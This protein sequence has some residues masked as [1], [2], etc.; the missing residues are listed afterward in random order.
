M[1]FP[2]PSSHKPSTEE[3]AGGLPGADWEGRA[4]FQGIAP[5]P[6]LN[7]DSSRSPCTGWPCHRGMAVSQR[8]GR[9]TEDS[10]QDGVIRVP[11]S[12]ARQERECK[13]ASCAQARAFLGPVSPAPWGHR[14]QG[15]QVSP[16]AKT[17]TGPLGKPP[18]LV[19]ASSAQ[20]KGR[21]S[22]VTDNGQ[23]PVAKEAESRNLPWGFVAVWFPRE[24]RAHIS[25]VLWV[26]DYFLLFF[27]HVS[28]FFCFNL[29]IEAICHLSKR[30][31]QYKFQVKDSKCLTAFALAYSS[32]SRS[33]QPATASRTSFQTRFVNTRVFVSV[34]VC[35][36]GR[37]LFVLN[38]P[39]ESYL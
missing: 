38:I 32:R 30:F 1:L 2:T 6:A 22:S 26:F 18:G 39:L 21:N 28:F 4:C 23:H 36:H 34:C 16:G 17:P 37:M 13:K 11:F 5:R 20:G 10:S 7:Y 25:P 31:K 24:D 29:K 19:P 9:V 14:L 12:S 35:T 33:Q 27:S 15:L 8:D 3:S